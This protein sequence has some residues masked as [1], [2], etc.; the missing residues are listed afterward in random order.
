MKLVALIATSVLA[1]T[2]LAHAESDTVPAPAAS[3]RM[4]LDLEVDPTAYVFSGWSVHA[5]IGWDKLRLDLGTYAM[6]IPEVLHGNDGWDA[7]FYGFGAKLQYFPLAVQEKLFVDA[8][9]GWSR[10]ETTLRETGS[11]TH[12]SGFGLGIDAGWR[13]ALPYNFYATP[14]AG[15]SYG[16]DSQDAMVG[17]KEFK[18]SR[19]TPFA[20]VHLGYRFR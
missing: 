7:S 18:M 13:F 8:S 6:D 5:G 15:I 17:G 19:W 9:L 1:S 20:A 11:S 10:Q 16:F 14:W 2:S 12:G 4:H 3:P